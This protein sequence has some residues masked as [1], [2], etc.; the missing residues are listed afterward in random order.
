MPPLLYI[1]LRHL[2][3]AV[4]LHSGLFLWPFSQTTLKWTRK[5]AVLSGSPAHQLFLLV[6]LLKQQCGRRQLPPET[7]RFQ[8][9]TAI[10]V[11]F[12]ARWRGAALPSW[13][14][15]TSTSVSGAPA[16]PPP[17]SVSKRCE[18]ALPQGTPDA[19]IWSQR[20]A[21]NASQSGPGV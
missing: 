2:S 4:F 8:P 1:Q 15:M 3:V 6:T 20:T 19:P 14:A 11:P 21:T 7:G 12:Q 13:V 9:S 18:A 16:L 17:P 10:T 5:C